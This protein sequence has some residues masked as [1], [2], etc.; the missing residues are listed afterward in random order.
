MGWFDG[1]KEVKAAKQAQDANYQREL[2]AAKKAGKKEIGETPEYLRL[3]TATNDAIKRSG[4]AVRW[5]N[6]G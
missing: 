3:N 6:G 2:K 1:A 5:W 4:K